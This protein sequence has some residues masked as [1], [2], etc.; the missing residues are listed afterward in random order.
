MTARCTVQPCVLKLAVIQTPIL[1]LLIKYNIT[2]KCSNRPSC[3]AVATPETLGCSWPEDVE[4]PSNRVHERETGRR[5][6]A[7]CAVSL[8]RY[9]PSAG[10]AVCHQ[11]RHGARQLQGRSLFDSH[12]PGRPGRRATRADDLDTKLPASGLEM[13]DC[14]CCV[15]FCKH[16]HAVLVGVWDTAK[17]QLPFC[18]V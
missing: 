7:A 15:W 8:C 13:E 6:S 14:T 1:I 10:A 16:N 4:T 17:P 3:W 9:P 18:L 11:A 5:S 12:K 2:W